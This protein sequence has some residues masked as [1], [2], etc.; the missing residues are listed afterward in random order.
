[1]KKVV[2]ERLKLQLVKKYTSYAVS[3]VIFVSLVISSVFLKTR[4]SFSLPVW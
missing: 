4:L 2:D 1:M 3:A